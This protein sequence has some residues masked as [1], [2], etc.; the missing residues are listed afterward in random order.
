MKRYENMKRQSIVILRNNE[1]IKY[2]LNME[3]LLCK[4][5]SWLPKR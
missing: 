4:S 3:S 5:N 1:I 2:Y